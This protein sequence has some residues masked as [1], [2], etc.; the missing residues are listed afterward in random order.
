[1]VISVILKLFSSGNNVHFTISIVFVGSVMSQ[2]PAIVI[3]FNQ[4]YF[5][6]CSTD[7]MSQYII[8]TEVDETA[9]SKEP[10]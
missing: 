6:F 10:I 4:N 2:F 5:S 7:A 3:Q 8:V 9:P 1:M